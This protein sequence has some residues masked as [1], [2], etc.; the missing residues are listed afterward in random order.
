[1]GC[2]STSSHPTPESYDDGIR[3]SSSTPKCGQGTGIIKNLQNFK[4]N[5]H[6]RE[7]EVTGT[8]E[9]AGSSAHGSAKEDGL[10][11]GAAS[12]LRDSEYQ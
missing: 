10:G 6:A 9:S 5:M 11:P 4:L 2:T 8:S 12:V 1:M 7:P 3:Q